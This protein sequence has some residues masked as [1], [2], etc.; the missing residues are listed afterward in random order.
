MLVFW[1]F[2]RGSARSTCAGD[3]QLLGC[4]R[5]PGGHGSRD[6]GVGKSECI[7]KPFGVG[8][9]SAVYFDATVVPM[10]LVPAT[11]ELLGDAQPV[12]AEVAGSGDAEVA[13]EGEDLQPERGPGTS[14][15][16]NYEGPGLP[17]VDQAPTRR[18]RSVEL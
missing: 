9:A 12:A 5:R 1:S 15:R 3:S 11:M 2:R 14:E 17:L 4:R 6:H 7:V 10:L 13:V 18:L 8:L 16:G